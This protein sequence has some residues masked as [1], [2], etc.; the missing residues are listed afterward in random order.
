MY[1]QAEFDGYSSDETVRVV[2]SG[3][4]EPRGVDITEAALDGNSAE[5]PHCRGLALGIKLAQAAGWLCRGGKGIALYF[6][7]GRVLAGS[8]CVVMENLLTFVFQQLEREHACMALQ[9][10]PC[11]VR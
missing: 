7:A 1:G 6:V 9:G 11:S 4:Q 3:N 10:Q 8:F 5:V 2:M